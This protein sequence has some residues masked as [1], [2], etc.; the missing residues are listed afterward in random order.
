MKEYDIEVLVCA[1]DSQLWAGIVLRDYESGVRA[2][3][4]PRLHF[5]ES[6][7]ARCKVIETKPRRDQEDGCARL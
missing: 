6:Q 3:C 1:F 2:S 7:G 5:R 4:L